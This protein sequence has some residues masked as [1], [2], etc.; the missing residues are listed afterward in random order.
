MAFV[1]VWLIIN[2]LFNPKLLI[3]KNVST[4]QKK[5]MKN[6]I[7]VIGAGATRAV[8]NNEEL[9]SPLATDFFKEEY[10]KHFDEAEYGEFESSE[11]N[12]I[13]THYF[14]DKES[15]NIEEIYSFL[16]FIENGFYDNFFEKNFIE[17]AKNQL[18]E[19]LFYLFNYEIKYDK[20]YYTQIIDK[21]KDGDSIISFNWDLVIDEILI[22]SK[23]GRK[24][25]NSLDE[26]INPLKTLENKDYESLAYNNLHKGYF[27]KM[28]GSIN[29]SACTNTKCLRNQVPFIYS[30]PTD[31][32]HSE[33]NCNY[34]GSKNEMMLM[35]PHINKKFNNNRIFSLQAKIAYNKINTAG[36]IFIIGYSFPEFD[37]E[38][39]AL[40]RKSKLKIGE[41]NNGFTSHLEEIHI[42][43][44]STSNKQFMEKIESIFGLKNQLNSFGN[45]IKLITYENID[46]FMAKNYAV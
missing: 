24:L 15:V 8:S 37:F 2:R 36:K 46:E 6:S 13:I 34:C 12:Q 27:L 10:L 19:Y 21:F 18:L 23:K 43:D 9:P 14:S 45:K 41:S 28:H 33:W 3:A 29:W 20:S 35:P 39:S 31:Y 25:T 7:F 17:K 22:K 42:V 30:I 44:P 11:L 1:W 38:A 16:E 26:I 5:I 32:T 40:F 4:N